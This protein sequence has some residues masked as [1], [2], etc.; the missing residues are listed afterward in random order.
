MRLHAFWRKT[1]LIVRLRIQARRLCI[2]GK[3]SGVTHILVT[4][5]EVLVKYSLLAKVTT[6]SGRKAIIC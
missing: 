4:Q 2:S 1:R 5:T 3:G 6:R